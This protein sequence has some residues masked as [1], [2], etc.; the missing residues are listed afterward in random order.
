MIEIFVGF[1]LG[2]MAFTDSGRQ[3]GNQ[4][5]DLAVSTAKKVLAGDAKTTDKSTEQSSGAAGHSGSAG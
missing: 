3:L 5:A 4:I 1:G 2:A